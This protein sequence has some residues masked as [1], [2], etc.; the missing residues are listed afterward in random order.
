MKM[1]ALPLMLVATAAL[2]AADNAP[3]TQ[4]S[5][6]MSVR[7]SKLIGMTV[8]NPQGES[9]ASVND[10]MID[11]AQAQVKYLAIS[12]GGVL[13]VGDKLFA[14][15]MKAFQVTYDSDN[16]QYKLVLNITSDRLEK[17]PG[18]NQD[19]WPDMGDKK[20]QTTVDEYYRGGRTIER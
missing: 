9:L 7:A 1:L 12:H 4:V 8:V 13:G 6:N 18:F 10:I 3:D 20:W 15:P 11:L 16:D 17:A 14:V 5:K 2:F 19:Q